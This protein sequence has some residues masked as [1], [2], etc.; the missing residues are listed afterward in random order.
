MENFQQSIRRSVVDEDEEGDEE[1]VIKIISIHMGPNWNMNV[2]ETWRDFAHVLIDN[3]ADF[4]IA[5]S[6]H[7]VKGIEVYKNKMISYGLGDF[8]NDYEGITGQGYERYRQDLTCLYLPRINKSNGELLTIDIIP[9]QIKNLK[10]QRTRNQNDIEW[11]CNAF[12]MQGKEL[13]TSCEQVKDVSGDVH[14]RIH[15]NS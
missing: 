9:C 12:S 2:P 7:H 8:L 5:H 10:V 15:W 3:G 4:V 11:L 14:L 6:S 1:D 13:G